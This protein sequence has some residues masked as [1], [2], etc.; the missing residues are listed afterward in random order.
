MTIRKD[1]LTE[2]SLRWDLQLNKNPVNRIQ[3]ENLMDATTRNQFKTRKLAGK[4]HLSLREQG[5]K[6]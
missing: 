6:T 1:Q 5:R 2:R 3:N 4:G